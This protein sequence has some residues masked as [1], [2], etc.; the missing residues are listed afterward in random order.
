VPHDNNVATKIHPRQAEGSMHI[1][2]AY[3]IDIGVDIVVT[4]LFN[5]G[6]YQ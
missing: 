6:T 2:V 1:V 5:I 4:H 3:F